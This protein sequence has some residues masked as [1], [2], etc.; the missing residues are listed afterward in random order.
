MF[1]RIQYYKSIFGFLVY[2]YL[3]QKVSNEILKPHQ[4]KLMLLGSVWMTT[5]KYSNAEWKEGNGL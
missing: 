5:A 2:I 3:F 4:N 1:F